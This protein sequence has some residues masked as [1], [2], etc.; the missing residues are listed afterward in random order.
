MLYQRLKKAWQWR[1]LSTMMIGYAGFYLNRQNVF[2]ALRD[3]QTEFQFDDLQYGLVITVFNV[4]YGISKALT[5][6]VSDRCNAR[7]FMAIGLLFACLANLCLVFCHSLTS[8]IMLC[9][10]N[11]IF[12]SMGWPAC[13]RLLTHWFTKKEIGTKWAVWNMSQQMG[14]LMMYACGALAIYKGHWRLMF[15]IPSIVGLGIV[16]YVFS[17]LRDTPE[18]IGLP[19]INAEPCDGQKPS[20]KLLKDNVYA[21][22]RVWLVGMA[23]FFVYFVRM[24]L[25][26]WAP[27]FL[28]EYKGNIKMASVTHTA[29][30]EVAGMIGGVVAGKLSDQIGDRG[31]VAMLFMLCVTVAIW[32]LWMLPAGTPIAQFL[33]MMC[34]GFFISGPQILIG[35]AASD[36]AGKKVAGAATGFTGVFGY[37]G[38]ALTGLGLGFVLKNFGWNYF[39]TLLLTASFC[40]VWLLFLTQKFRKVETA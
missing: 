32:S 7:H 3:I 29:I 17:R 39:F 35:V 23:N 34:I 15:L 6:I 2:L 26:G 20:F 31:K 16:V 22:P 9:A 24:A 36:F 5:G 27:K 28:F 33:T 1:I 40:C 11:A 12:Q 4:L 19:T 25:V 18:S 30:Y 37:A 21:N 8:L 10:A 14:S 13:A 38:G